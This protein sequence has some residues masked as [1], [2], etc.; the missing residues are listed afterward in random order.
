MLK[1]FVKR[2][3]KALEITVKNKIWAVVQINI[4]L[5]FILFRVSQQ[6]KR[7]ERGR[8]ALWPQSGRVWGPGLLSWRRLGSGCSRRP[9]P[10]LPAASCCSW[11][12]LAAA[13]LAGVHLEATSQPP[14]RQLPEA[15]KELMALDWIISAAF[16][17]PSSAEPDNWLL[18]TSC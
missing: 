17:K 10:A 16:I 3:Q 4:Y 14:I 6:S 1:I 13:S 18:V 5:K 8:P 12:E 2:K 9:S 7:A 11:P 15:D